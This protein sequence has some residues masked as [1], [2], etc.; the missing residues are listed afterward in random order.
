MTSQFN[1]EPLINPVQKYR[2]LVVNLFYRKR[3][4]SFPKKRLPVS[5]W[6]LGIRIGKTQHCREWDWSNSGWFLL[7]QVRSGRF[8]TETFLSYE[9]V[10]QWWWKDLDSF[11]FKCW[12]EP[13]YSLYDIWYWCSTST[14]WYIFMKV[15]RSEETAKVPSVY[16]KRLTT[17]LSTRK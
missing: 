4:S 14:Y 5:K 1:F 13:I 11:R 3:R 8:R 9:I 16:I 12:V 10:K 2:L 6:D 15:F 17:K 7:L